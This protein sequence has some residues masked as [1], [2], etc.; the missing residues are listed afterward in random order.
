MKFFLNF[1]VYPGL[2][3]FQMQ[4]L[5]TAL[6]FARRNQRIVILVFISETNLAGQRLISRQYFQFFLI[7]RLV[8]WKLLFVLF[9]MLLDDLKGAVYLIDKQFIFHLVH[10]PLVAVLQ[11]QKLNSSQFDDISW[12]K[13]KSLHAIFGILVDD[14]EGSSRLMDRPF[15]LFVFC[16]LIQVGFVIIERFNDYNLFFSILVKF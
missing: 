4:K 2:Q 11:N 5:A 3:T 16:Q 12:D 10:F 9:I 15:D 6:A 8:I 1:A 7:L 13:R 14:D